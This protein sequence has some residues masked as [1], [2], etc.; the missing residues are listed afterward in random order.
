MQRSELPVLEESCM[1]FAR[2]QHCFERLE[3]TREEL[4]ELFKVRPRLCPPRGQW[5]RPSWTPL[6]SL[7]LT[8]PMWLS[9]ASLPA[10]Q[11]LPAAA[12]LGGGDDP[13]SHCV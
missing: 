12:N 2:S 10:A 11:Q 6:V 3:A 7:M 8:S 4:L 1:A 13:N 5:H 9:P